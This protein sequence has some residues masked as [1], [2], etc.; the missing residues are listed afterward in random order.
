MV[1][2][3]LISLFPVLLL[4]LGANAHGVITAV[5]GANGVTSQAFG[6]IASTPRDGSTPVPFEQD[7]SVIRNLEIQTGQT[8]VCGKTKAGGNNEVTTQL[9]Q[10]VAAGLPSAAADGSVTMTLHQVN[11]DGAGPY[12]CEVSTDATGQN[13]AAMTVTTNV[14]GFDSLSLAQA[15]DFPLVAQL[16]AGTN[17]TGGPDGNACLVRCKNNAIAGPFGGCTAVTT[18]SSGSSSA[19]SAAGSAT[20]A[21]STAATASVNEAAAA[22]TPTAASTKAK[23]GLGGAL[24]SILG[25][26]VEMAGGALEA[27]MEERVRRSRVYAGARN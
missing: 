24:K 2:A 7:T 22:P 21:A 4:S 17:C 9:N 20:E 8:G 14:P 15:T 19:S 25:K 12:T 6:V 1:F 27:R 18:S 3:P 23:G 10:A 16:P 11:Q 5:T 13:F 26:R